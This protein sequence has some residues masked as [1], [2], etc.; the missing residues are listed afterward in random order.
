[1]G[2]RYMPRMPVRVAI[3][4]WVVNPFARIT[5]TFGTDVAQM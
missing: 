4:S 2:L 1:M 3:S 5:V